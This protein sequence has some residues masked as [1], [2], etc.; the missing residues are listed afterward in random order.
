MLSKPLC[1]FAMQV[2]LMLSINHPNVVG[3]AGALL[4]TATSAVAACRISI[5]RMPV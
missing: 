5:C 2:Q 3:A 1:G 4:R